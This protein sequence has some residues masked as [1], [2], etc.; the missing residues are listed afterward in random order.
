M[1]DRFVVTESGALLDLLSRHFSNWSKNKLRQRLQLG[2][3]QVN[4]ESVE[5]RGP[6]LQPGDVVVVL[7]TR[8][9]E[10][11]SRGTD[12]LAPLFTDRDLLAIDKPAGLL[13]VSTDAERDRTAHALLRAANVGSKD[14]WPCHRLDRETS[15]VLL[16]ARSTAVRDLVQADWSNVRKVYLAVVEGHLEVENGTIEQPLWEDR[17]LRV[18]VGAHASAKHARTRYRTLQQGR[19]CSLLEVELDTGRKHQI[20]AHL[21]FVGHAIVGDDRYGSAAR[22][23]CLH[24]WRLALRHP[25]SGAELCIEAPVPA[26][27]SRMLPPGLALG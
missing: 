14:L 13:S 22:G 12:R 2:C 17:N 26:A 16:F 25:G 6:L 4:G 15:G 5:A 8:S 1:A 24:A 11:P 20:R 18:R 3:V 21:A 23:L 27:L 10:R 19:N 9:A 7:S